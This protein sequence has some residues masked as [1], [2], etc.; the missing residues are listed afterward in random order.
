M[1]RRGLT[2]AIISNGSIYFQKSQ[3]AAFEVH[4]SI[5]Q[6]FYFLKADTGFLAYPIIGLR[7]RSEP[8]YTQAF[9]QHRRITADFALIRGAASGFL[10]KHHR[11]S[12]GFWGTASDVQVTRARVKPRSGENTAV[13]IVSE[14]LYNCAVPY[15]G[16]ALLAFCD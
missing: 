11:N 14:T 1:F 16:C 4:G 5:A 12:Y 10:G 8:E 13:P 2:S 15:S 9:R 3:P 7:R 6:K